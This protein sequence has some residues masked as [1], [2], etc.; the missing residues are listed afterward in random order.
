[1]YIHHNCQSFQTLSYFHQK[2]RLKTF[3]ENVF[4]VFF[5]DIKKINFYQI[6]LH[7]FLLYK[8]IHWD[9]FHLFSNIINSFFK[10]FYELVWDYNLVIFKIG[11]IEWR[12]YSTLNILCFLTCNELIIKIKLFYREVKLFSNREIYW[13]NI[14]GLI[15]LV[16]EIN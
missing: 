15:T 7:F 9:I 1:M 13:W 10:N 11:I 3:L 16:L 2:K 8:T 5:F 12:S 6:Y 4:S 14:F